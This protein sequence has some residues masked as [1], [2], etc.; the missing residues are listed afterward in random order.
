MYNTLHNQEA[1]RQD[2]VLKGGTA[3]AFVYKGVTEAAVGFAIVPMIW[4][5]VK[6]RQ[7]TLGGL[8]RLFDIKNS[9]FNL[10]SLEILVKAGMVSF[11]G[12]VIT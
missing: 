4:R 2:Y 7:F 6:R 5:T 3:F 8:D 10:L 1:M 9:I 11:F 12:I